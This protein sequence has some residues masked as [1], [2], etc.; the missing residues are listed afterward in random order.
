MFLGIPNGQSNAWA[1]NIA[2][3]ICLF[4]PLYCDIINLTSL[5]STQAFHLLLSSAE[6]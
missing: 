6:N 2:S 4:Y 1:N 5:K 3:V